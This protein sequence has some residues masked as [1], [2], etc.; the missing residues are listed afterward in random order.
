MKEIHKFSYTDDFMIPNGELNYFLGDV[1]SQTLLRMPQQRSYEVMYL[2][3]NSKFVF[4]YMWKKFEENLD[5]L[6]A[7][8]DD[9]LSSFRLKKCSNSFIGKA[10]KE[11]TY[12]FKSSLTEQRTP[13]NFGMM[14]NPYTGETRYLSLIMLYVKDLFIE[15]YGK[16]D[17]KEHFDNLTTEH[18]EEF[19]RVAIHISTLIDTILNKYPPQLQAY[20][21]NTGWSFMRVPA[22]IHEDTFKDLIQKRYMLVVLFLCFN[23]IELENSKGDNNTNF[24]INN[25]SYSKEDYAKLYYFSPLF[26]WALDN[27]ETIWENEDFTNLIVPNMI[28][29]DK[30]LIDLFE[31]NKLKAPIWNDSEINGVKEELEALEKYLNPTD[32]DKVYLSLKYNIPI[33]AWDRKEK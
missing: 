14:S 18:S 32:E 22:L 23:A 1:I 16:D 28:E 11:L 27:F 17:L 26:T 24:F 20:A 9:A 13:Y 6:Y 19:N 33:N 31:Q 12:Y 5:M 7:N 4:D 3:S 30:I 29:Y 10:V 15:W 21:I 25:V 8:Y 2:D